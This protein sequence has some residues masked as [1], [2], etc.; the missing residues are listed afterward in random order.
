VVGS[1]IANILLILGV[2]ALIAP[3]ATTKK[4]FLRDGSAL[5]AASLILVGVCVLGTLGRGIGMALVLLLVA[6]VWLSF[7]LDRRGTAAAADL[8]REQAEA[9]ELR[10]SRLW[11]AV[12][13]S[14]TGL[15]ALVGGAALLVE[16]ALVIA[17]SSGIS[18]TVIG[19]TVVAVGT[20]L[21]ELA[22]S[23]VAAL[24]RQSDVAFGNIV[25]SNI[26]NI[27]GIL[28]VTALVS[29]MAIPDRIAAFDVWLMLGVTMAAVAF[30][31]SG[32]RIC[33]WEGAVLLAAYLAYTGAL[34]WPSTSTVLG[35]P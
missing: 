20:S 27:L 22:T 18:E 1:N 12:V 3:I 11:V 28:G 23:V 35:L 17:R 4:A 32:W 24:R 26:F 13:W 15:A 9:V 7:W 19:L 29:P 33:R 21:P 6:Y 5:M 10:P 25:G 14:L 30:A 31:V 16:G 34:F 8:H 2:S